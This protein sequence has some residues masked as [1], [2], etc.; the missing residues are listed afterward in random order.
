MRAGDS[1][2]WMGR[3]YADARSF[4]QERNRCLQIIKEPKPERVKRESDVELTRFI[5][6]VRKE[7][8][9]PALQAILARRQNKPKNNA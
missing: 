2:P 5:D 4:I 8:L 1:E 7:T 9:S 6:D 3:D